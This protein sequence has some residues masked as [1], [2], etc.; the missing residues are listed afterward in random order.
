MLA[1]NINAMPV[2]LAELVMWDMPYGLG[3]A[4]WD[5]LLSDAE[6][7]VFFQQLAV[8]NRAKSHALVLGVVWHDAGRIR[9][10]MEDHGY[11]DAHCV[12]PCKP[13][14]NMTGMEWIF[15]VEV[16]VCGYKGGIRSCNLTFSSMNP[17]FRHNFF[18]AHQVHGKL[19][20]LGE[21]AEVNTTQKNPNVASFLGRIMCK[22]GAYALVIGAGSGSEVLGLAR[23]GVNVVA[24]ERDAKQFR[25]LTA[26]L[27]AEASNPRKA[28]EQQREEEAQVELL[29]KLASK[30]TKLNTDVSAHFADRSEEG[31]SPDASLAAEDPSAAGPAAGAKCPSCGQELKPSDAGRSARH[32]CETGVLPA[33]C[34][35]ACSKCA[36]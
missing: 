1:I 13:Q 5:V 15:A 2:H 9:K 6:L 21:D 7:E 25:A 20:H 12:F 8:V 19:R 3:L 33:E 17:V 16:I 32:T 36:K 29:T 34:L 14:Q 24:V 26:R 31:S 30:F 4:D 11:F 28:L 22:P 18:F 23:I 27:T 35:L 10:F